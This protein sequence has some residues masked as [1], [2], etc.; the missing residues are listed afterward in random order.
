MASGVYTLSE[1]KS[2]ETRHVPQQ[3]LK[4]KVSPTEP[5]LD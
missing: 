2:Q 3:V 1:Q 5:Q 4:R